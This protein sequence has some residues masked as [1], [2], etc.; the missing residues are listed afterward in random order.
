MSASPVKKIGST[1]KT[2][3]K[4]VKKISAKLWAKKYFR[5]V[6][7]ITLIAGAGYG[8]FWAGERHG[9]ERQKKADAKTRMP[10]SSQK[11]NGAKA[12][13]NQ[14]RF[15]VMG[16]VTKVT[17]SSIEVKSQNGTTSTIA[18][19]KN[20]TITNKKGEKQ[21]AKSLKADQKVIVSGS[22]KPDKSQ[23]AERIR[24]QS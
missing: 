14:A 19:D 17:D 8:L 16:T 11:S 20:T 3:S 22:T 24:I 7:V 10:F 6:L 13:P 18:I 23:T 9:A 15:N 21:D 2:A 5:I 12:N 1:L 4:K